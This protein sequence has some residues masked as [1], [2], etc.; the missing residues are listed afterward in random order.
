ME[1]TVQKKLLELGYDPERSEAGSYTDVFAISQG[2]LKGVA[3]FSGRV[4]SNIVTTIL[5][6]NY[7]MASSVRDEN[8]VSMYIGPLEKI[9]QEEDICLKDMHPSDKRYI[10]LA[11]TSQELGTFCLVVEDVRKNNIATFE[12]WIRGKMLYVPKRADI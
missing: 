1:E 6:D 9:F 5:D 3:L 10:D 8:L 2:Y 11:R 12:F 4:V 7:L